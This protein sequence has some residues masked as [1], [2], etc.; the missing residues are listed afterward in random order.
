MKERLVAV[1]AQPLTLVNARDAGFFPGQLGG[2]TLGKGTGAG[3]IFFA[4]DGLAFQ[5]SLHLAGGGEGPVPVAPLGVGFPFVQP[6]VDLCRVSS[7]R[8]TASSSRV[9]SQLR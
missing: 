4:K 8:R 5:Q 9:N 3:R 7:M 1:P 2:G 6:T